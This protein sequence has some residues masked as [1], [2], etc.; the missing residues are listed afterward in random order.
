MMTR[1]PAWRAA[2]TVVSA[3]SWTGVARLELT[4]P[5]ASRQETWPSITLH[6]Q[7]E[8]ARQHVA[9]GAVS[10]SGGPVRLP[11][12]TMRCFRLSNPAVLPAIARGGHGTR[13]V[14]CAGEAVAAGYRSGGMCARAARSENT[15]RP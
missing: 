6:K 2:V 14:L 3:I 13:R 1:S 7:A 10:C 15:H 4:W 12:M 9:G 5:G 8:G 11:P